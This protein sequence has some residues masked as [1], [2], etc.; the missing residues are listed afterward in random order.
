MEWIAVFR[1]ERVM[2]VIKRTLAE[3]NGGR[4]VAKSYT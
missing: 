2:I 4:K 1:D 3:R